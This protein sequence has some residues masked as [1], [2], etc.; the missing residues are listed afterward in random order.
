[1]ESD[2]H[3]GIPSKHLNSFTMNLETSSFPALALHSGLTASKK[4]TID[5][6]S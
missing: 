3:N 1:M 2:M 5:I 6:A 4:R